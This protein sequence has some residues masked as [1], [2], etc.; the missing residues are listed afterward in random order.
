M[1]F[2]FF[3]E[4]GR[5]VS[6]VKAFLNLL[7]SLD[8]GLIAL[9]ALARSVIVVSKLLV[10][11]SEG[12]FRLSRTDDILGLILGIF[13]ILL[14]L[15]FSG[16]L[17]EGDNLV[18]YTTHILLDGV[19]PGFVRIDNVRCISLDCG[20]NQAFVSYGG[21]DGVVDSEHIFCM[22]MRGLRT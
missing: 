16:A 3:S 14:K 11:G 19:R 12:S 5:V 17:E 18:A 6:K 1:L 15:A 4:V 21:P 9:S 7:L 20:N 8:G 22:I 10:W 13:G 2:R